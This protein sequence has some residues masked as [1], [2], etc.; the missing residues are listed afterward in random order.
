MFILGQRMVQKHN[1]VNRS[2]AVV[3]EAAGLDQM[4]YRVN[5]KCHMN[6]NAGIE[7]VRDEDTTIK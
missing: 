6:A 7:N 3:A 4:I 1:D 2:R 5:L